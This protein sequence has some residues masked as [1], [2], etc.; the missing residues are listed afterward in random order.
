MFLDFFFLLRSSGIS[1]SPTSF[2]RLN[3]ALSSGLVISIEDFYTVAR[4]I[5]VKSERFFD[6]Y[7]QVFAHY[8][9][10]K[11]LPDF[12]GEMIDEMAKELLDAWLADSS[13]ISK[14]LGVDENSLKQ[15]SPDEL[16]DYFKARLKEQ[17]K[18]HQGGNKWIGT[19]GTSPVGHSGFHPGG[20]RVGGGSRGRSAVKVAMER[21]FKDYSSEGVLTGSMMKEALKRLK[22]MLPAGPM[23]RIDIEKSIYQT[24][25]NGGEIEIIFSRSL[26]DK[27]K[28]VL[29]IDNGGWS[30]DPFVGVV[31]QLFGHAHN[32]FKQIDTYFFHNTVY[33]RVW[34]DP[35][36]LKRPVLVNDLLKRDREHRVFIVGDASM[37][38]YELMT[39]G[40]NIS[41][42][43]ST[44][45]TSI[46]QWGRMTKQFPHMVWLNPVPKKMWRYTQTIG[47]INQLIP[48]YELSL[49]GLEQ[50][51]TYLNS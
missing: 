8:F 4:S 19:G 48:M 29:L 36:R 37:A 5:L 32:H 39:P 10:G 20:M 33:E 42:H 49:D 40:G 27:L 35:Q 34:E 41:I 3:L 11:E 17:Q 18:R 21:R 38:P 9:D 1:V 30:M 2:L 44:Y 12:E 45:T 6:L 14:L 47:V 51:I 22:N 26:K 43:E 25:R 15:Y 28:L 23:D 31:Q 46:E 24:M 7:D 13:Q 50:A 16:L